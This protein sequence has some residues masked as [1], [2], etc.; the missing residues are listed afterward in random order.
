M[1]SLTG[2][3]GLLMLGSILSPVFLSAEVSRAQTGDRIEPS[4]S[5]PKTPVSD[6]MLAP[7]AAEMFHR[8]P[9][10]GLPAL[11]NREPA[12]CDIRRIKTEP[13]LRQVLCLVSTAQHH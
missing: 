13:G 9:R 10:P 3:F 1:K 11:G 8:M 2:V 5:K 7:F 6:F 4:I 12:D